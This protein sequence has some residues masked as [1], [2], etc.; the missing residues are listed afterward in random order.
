MNYFS[1]K[2][3]QQDIEKFVGPLEPQSRDL[4]ESDYPGMSQE[5]TRELKALTELFISTK[6]PDLAGLRW[7][8]M[9]TI[10]EAYDADEDELLE[11]YEVDESELPLFMS[12]F[13]VLNDQGNPFYTLGE[14]GVYVASDDPWEIE[15]VYPDVE[16]F[17]RCLILLTAVSTGKA[18]FSVVR[19]EF[20]DVFGAF[21][22]HRF[23]Q[24]AK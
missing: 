19:T 6:L 1:T 13:E 11:E 4:G 14:K 17:F 7:G 16:K 23:A 20:G 9:C 21:G 15:V 18:E 24:N 2:R 3:F 8:S 22:E 10:P 12:S 5:L